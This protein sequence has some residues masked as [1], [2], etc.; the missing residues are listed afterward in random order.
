MINEAILALI[1]LCA[2]DVAPNTVAQIIRVESKGNP[3]AIN[4]NGINKRFEATS[5][6]E[7][8][9]ITREY[10][11]E[12]YSVDVGLM[13]INSNNF[14][15]LGYADNIEGLFEACNNITAGSTV[16]KNFYLQSQ[17]SF[18]DKG[19]A[20]QGAISAY[21]TGDFERGVA[22]GY[23]GK[24]YDT[25]DFGVSTA[26]NPQQQQLSMALKAPTAVNIDILVKSKP[27]YALDTTNIHF[28]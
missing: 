2:P 26:P 22:N 7:A 19:K 12:G 24:V 18:K 15:A 21:N 23:V 6:A 14:A 1:P 17:K 20:L 28:R 10:I 27:D 3:L 4:V 11:K 13:Q 5:Q 9:A 16:L 8:A 25:E